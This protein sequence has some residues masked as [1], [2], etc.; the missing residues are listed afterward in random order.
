MADIVAG[1]WDTAIL[2][3]SGL[4]DATLPK[5][6]GTDFEICGYAHIGGLDMPVYPGY[7]DQQAAALGCLPGPGDA[8]INVATGAQVTVT[9]KNYQTGPYE[10]RPYFSGG[11]LKTIPH[12]PGGRSLD[13]LMQFVRR[14]AEEVAGIAIHPETAWRAIHAAHLEPC[15][16]TV[17]SR[18]H[19]TDGKHLAGGTISGT[20]PDNFTIGSLFAAMFLDMAGIYWDKLNLVGD[21][22]D[23]D[24][25]ICSGGVSWRN[26]GLIQAGSVPKAERNELNHSFW[27]ET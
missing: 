20:G 25:L 14:T 16:L 10:T 22:A 13:V 23:I 11:F 21:G 3:R 24:R 6:A 8:I 19:S 9:A 18:F 15:G 27:R 26:P 17:N 12:L 2:E 7:G 5:I 4:G 1:T